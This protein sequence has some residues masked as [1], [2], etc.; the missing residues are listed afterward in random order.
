MVLVCIGGGGGF[1]GSH[2]GMFLKKK[3]YKVR[4]VDWKR[5]E[6]FKEEEFCDE[7]VLLD[8]RSLDN[9][10]KA[11]KDCEWVFNFAADMGG[12]GFIQSN[13][14]VILYNNIM[15]SSNMLEAARING[16]KRFFW[17]SSACV[18]PN[19]KQTE[20]NVTAL[21]E[22]DAWPADPQDAY[23]LEKITT[24]ELCQH[25]AKDFGMVT[26]IGR[27]HNIYGPHGTWKGG[28]EKAPAAFSRKAITSE[29]EFEMWG[30]GE[31]TR[32]F[33]Y[34]DD[35]VEGVWRLFQSD[36]EKPINIGSDEMISMNDMAKLCMS[37]EG[38]DLP[39]KH[40]PGPEG[41]RGRNSDNTLIK[42]VLG[43][44]PSISLKDGLKKTWEWIKK[45]I[46]DEKTKGI[47][48]DYTKSSIVKLDSPIAIGSLLDEKK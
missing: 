1:L 4:C 25:Y 10:L 24:E 8:L 14:S 46:E 13:H 6:Y 21:K 7:F 32:S 42:Q 38:K 41:V 19:Y 35:L 22:S 23:G 12:M 28:R 26:R 34:V 47:K 30:D 18:Y 48:E 20:T 36:Y 11:S 3:G 9:C 40:I 44:A 37:F 27:F 43:W 29:T 16:V 33:C 31:Q 45:E 2:M 17:S 39:I 5:N 15:I